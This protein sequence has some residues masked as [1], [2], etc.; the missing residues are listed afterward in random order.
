MLGNPLGQPLGMYD[1]V[2]AS[3]SDQD[4]EPLDLSR[5]SLA[6]SPELAVQVLPD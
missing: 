6:L 1:E 5:T 2:P 4:S 3:C